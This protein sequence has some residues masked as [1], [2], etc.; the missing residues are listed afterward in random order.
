MK[1]SATFSDCGKYRYSLKREWDK[2]KPFVL[3]ICLN[4]STADDKN[5]DPTLIRCISY[6]KQWGYGGVYVTN[7][8][9]YRAT[10]PR[11]MLSS[12]DPIGID[13]D[14]RLRKLSKSAG[15]VVAAWGNHGKH[16]GRSDE[17]RK[18]VSNL[19]YLKL[20]ASGEPSHPLYLKS[21]LKPKLS[22]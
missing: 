10:N 18:A 8:F 11:D 21:N 6:A 5:D 2:D 15:L 3:F 13:N 1:S 4:P 20:N 12:Q 22:T 17:I 7:L 14:K 19:Y 9:A 16:I